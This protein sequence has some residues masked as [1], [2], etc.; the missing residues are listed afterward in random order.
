MLSPNMQSPFI[1]QITIPRSTYAEL[2]R[3]P[4]DQGSATHTIPAILQAE[5]AESQLRQRSDEA[6]ATLHRSRSE[7]ETCFLFVSQRRDCRAS[8]RNCL[9]P[10][11]ITDSICYED[12]SIVS[13]IRGWL[14]YELD[15]LYRRRPSIRVVQLRSQNLVELIFCLRDCAGNCLVE[16]LQKAGDSVLQ[17]IRNEARGTVLRNL[18]RCLRCQSDVRGCRADAGRGSVARLGMRGEKEG[19]TK[20]DI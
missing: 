19:G 18:C 9:L 10:S 7:S 17:R 4:I 12:V 11:S 8:L 1:C 20:E 6:A 14:T 16:F 3:I 2:S 13:L 15:K 5:S